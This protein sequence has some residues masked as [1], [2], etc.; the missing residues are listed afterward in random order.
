MSMRLRSEAVRSAAELI[1]LELLE[2]EVKPV[3]ERLQLLLDG[4]DTFAH[5]VEDLAELNLRF[6]ARWE[7][8]QA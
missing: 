5:L 4:S 1:G 7:V 6:D 2:D 8:E 3:R